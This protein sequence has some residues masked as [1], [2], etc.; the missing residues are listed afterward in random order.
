MV[1]ALLE[2]GA[3][4]DH[5]DNVAGYSARDYARRDARARDVLKL[6]ED[7]R[8]KKTASTAAN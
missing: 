4:P 1:K 2:A 7:L 6:I 8:P 5:S 3:D